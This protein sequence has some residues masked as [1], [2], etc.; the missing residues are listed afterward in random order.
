[1]YEQRKNSAEK[2]VEPNLNFYVNL[3]LPP[4]YLCFFQTNIITSPIVSIPILFYYL[5]SCKE[6][7]KKFNLK[8]NDDKTHVINLM[9]VK[10]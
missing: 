7:A 2:Y 4:V 3:P 10:M 6:K 1:M 9:R 8:A 5:P